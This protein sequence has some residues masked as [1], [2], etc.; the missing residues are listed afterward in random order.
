MDDV[1]GSYNPA[2]YT[3]GP[4]QILAAG[5]LLLTHCFNDGEIVAAKSS[6]TENLLIVEKVTVL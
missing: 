4:V 5:V 1:F 6:Q 2:F 3:A